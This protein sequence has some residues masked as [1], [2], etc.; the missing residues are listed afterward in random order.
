[1]VIKKYLFILSFLSLV[2]AQDKWY[3]I[4]GSRQFSISGVAKFEKGFLVVHDNKK[5]KQPRISYIDKSFKLRKLVW[6]EPKLPY[7]LEALHKMPH[8]T[9]KFIAMESTGKAYLFFVDPFDFRIELIQTFTLPGISNKMN[10]EGLAV[11]NSAQGQ[12][13]IYGDRGSNKRSSTLITALYEPTNHNIY[14]V[15]KFVI[16]LPFP[17]NDKRNIADLAI[18]N[19]G[20]V[21]TSATSD[22]GNDGPFQTAIYHIGQM[23]NVGTFNF[24]HP[25][26]L[27]PLMIIDNQ[28]VEAMI[29]N[30][31]RLIL[32]TDN[33]NFGATFLQIKE[34]L[35]D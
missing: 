13:F 3:Q 14:E 26:L 6:P 8:Y 27:K 17:E 28:K 24:N 15:N 31:E 12:V 5:K 2:I 18:D 11:F 34:L 16:E 23:S 9:N 10:L 20:G 19:N 29:F 33:E 35:N 7:D 21:W 4:H 22:P 30:K 32:M 25:S 1:M